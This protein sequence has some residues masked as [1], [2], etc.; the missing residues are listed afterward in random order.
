[1]RV[2]AGTALI[3]GAAVL[4]IG[5]A[6]A[7]TA[8][9]MLADRDDAVGVREPADVTVTGVRQQYRGDVSLRD[10]PQSVQVLSAEKLAEAGVTRLD[11]ALD[12]AS[13][14]SRQNNFGGFF[15]SFAIRGFAGDEQTASNY[16]LNGFNAS[17]GYGGIRD[18]SNVDGSRS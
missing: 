16:L 14:V 3:A 13:G 6:Q 2:S 18:T 10:L 15:D 4:G 12:F 1:M 8:A 7:Q 9:A 11:D 5:S 17:R